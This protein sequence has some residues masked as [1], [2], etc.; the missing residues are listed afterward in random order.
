MN[1]G[2][3]MIGKFF[4]EGFVCVDCD[5]Y[6]VAKKE[7]RKFR[8]PTCGETGKH[9]WPIVGDQTRD[10]FCPKCGSRIPEDATRKID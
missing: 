7:L 1:K 5:S 8:C 9:V 4:D 6:N 2:G 3:F 10:Y